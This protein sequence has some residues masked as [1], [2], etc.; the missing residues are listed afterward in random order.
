MLYNEYELLEL[1]ENEPIVMADEQTGMFMYIKNDDFGF[2]LILNISQHEDK[3]SVSLSYEKIKGVIFDF[4]LEGIEQIK[5]EDNHLIILGNDDR[6]EVK[7]SV[8][9]HFGLKTVK[10]CN[11]K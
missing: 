6:T 7:I 2:K 4:E 10:L 3:C 5:G 11:S 9:P 1:F 8:K